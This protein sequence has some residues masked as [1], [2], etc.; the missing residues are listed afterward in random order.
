MEVDAGT[1]QGTIVLT[2]RLPW[3]GMYS[4]TFLR[5]TLDNNLLERLQ[6]CL[7]LG[8]VDLSVPELLFL[9]PAVR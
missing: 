6:A 4:S 7:L 3:M 5:M 2:G 1:V 9:P 8:L